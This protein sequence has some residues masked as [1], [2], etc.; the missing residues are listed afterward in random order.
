[1]YPRMPHMLVSAFFGQKNV[2]VYP[3]RRTPNL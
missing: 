1:V 3:L 2:R